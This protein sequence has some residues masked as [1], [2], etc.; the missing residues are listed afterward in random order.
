MKLTPEILEQVAQVCY[1]AQREL[2]I[3]RGL[4]ALNTEVPPVWVIA[5]QEAK[6][7]AR[8][9]AEMFMAARGRL[10]DAPIEDRICAGI[11]GA[12]REHL[13]GTAAAVKRTD[14]TDRELV[15]A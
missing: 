14:K 15:V 3:S 10:L 1:A 2:I 6:H 8:C 4:S 13:A 9:R 12:F 11:A 5:T 7:V